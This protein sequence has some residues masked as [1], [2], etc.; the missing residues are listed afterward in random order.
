MNIRQ[1]TK[2]A[3]LKALFKDEKTDL[4][5]SLSHD[6]FVISAIYINHTGSFVAPDIHCL[7]GMPIKIKAQ[8]L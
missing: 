4:H 1:G 8:A 6:D 5:L 2:S 7:H 3:I